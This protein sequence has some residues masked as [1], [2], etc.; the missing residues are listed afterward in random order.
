MLFRHPRVS[1][2]HR[3]ASRPF[4]DT[5]PGTTNAGSFFRFNFSVYIDVDNRERDKN[6]RRTISLEEK[7]KNFIAAVRKRRN[8]SCHQGENERQLK[9]VNR[10]TRQHFLHKK[11][12]W[13]VSGSFTLYSFKTTA[14]KCTKKKRAKLFFAN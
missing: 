8:A 5:K 10:N 4:R 13:K 1:A 6:R 12:N 14:K 9:K 3:I 11:C 7:Q 2:V